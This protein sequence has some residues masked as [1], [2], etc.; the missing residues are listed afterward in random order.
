METRRDAAGECRR[1]VE[2]LTSLPVCK[3]NVE[4]VFD[5]LA[6]SRLERRWL[7]W[8]DFM[9]EHAHLDAWLQLAEQAVSCPDLGHATYVVAK[10]ELRRFEVSPVPELQSGSR[11]RPYFLFCSKIKILNILNTRSFACVFRGCAARPGRGSSSWTVWPAGTE[12]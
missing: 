10:E 1:R 11:Q 6:V 7:L 9:K 5:V 12:R 4:R 8:H 3:I 2:T